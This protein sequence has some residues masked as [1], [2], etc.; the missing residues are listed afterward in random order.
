MML[1]KIAEKVATKQ[2]ELRRKKL[3]QALMQKFHRQ[4]SQ[5]KADLTQLNE[6]PQLLNAIAMADTFREIC[7]SIGDDQKTFGTFYDFLD[8]V[9]REDRAMAQ[10]IDSMKSRFESDNPEKFRVEVKHSHAD[11]S[12]IISSLRNLLTDFAEDEKDRQLSQ[13]QKTQEREARNQQKVANKN[14]KSN[15]Q[16]WSSSITQ[17]IETFIR[18][19]A[20]SDTSPENSP[21][22]IQKWMQNQIH[23]TL[24]PENQTVITQYRSKMTEKEYL[25]IQLPLTPAQE[26]KIIKTVCNEVRLQLNV[27]ETQAYY[28]HVM[29]LGETWLTFLEQTSTALSEEKYVRNAIFPV[30]QVLREDFQEL[31]EWISRVEV[32]YEKTTSHNPKEPKVEAKEK[33][34]VLQLYEESRKERIRQEENLR[35]LQI[36]KKKDQ[37]LRKR[38]HEKER[39]EAKV[40][41]DQN[42]G[43]AKQLREKERA[44]NKVLKEQ[45]KQ[46][47]AELREIQK[48]T[49]QGLKEQ[50][51]KEKEANDILKAQEK[52]ERAKLKEKERAE[53]K[54]L[55]AQEK[56]KAA[57]LREAQ[58]IVDQDLINQK[59]QEKERLK[60]KAEKKVED[61]PDSDEETDT[62]LTPKKSTSKITSKK[63]VSKP[64]RKKMSKKTPKKTTPQPKKTSQN[65]KTS[66]KE[67]KKR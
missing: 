42:R 16:S 32:K 27:F 18:P 33:L 57:E 12:Y 58:K 51:K 13:D 23:P 30:R 4:S 40:L 14:G 9:R 17:K 35:I 3:E 2:S 11:F 21:S 48:K 49:D 63:N 43:K 55:K 66:D 67:E 7:N 61:I 65:N 26:V 20:T 6:S 29:K 62:P 46:K 36:V 41:R 1:K 15:R 22:K 47:A 5:I 31:E 28:T 44:E 45:E 39:A 25:A 54:A 56:Q 38:L 34:R 52:Q 24:L 37:E 59:K 8:L 60:K 50:K 10:L 53:T 19:A 64:P